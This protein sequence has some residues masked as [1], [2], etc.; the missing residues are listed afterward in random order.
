MSDTSVDFPFA[1]IPDFISHGLDESRKQIAK[2][3][4]IDATYLRRDG[5]LAAEPGGTGGKFNLLSL[6]AWLA[7]AERAGVPFVPARRIGCVPID[8]VCRHLWDGEPIEGED[9]AAWTA[10]CRAAGEMGP[11]EILRWDFASSGG[12]K[13]RMAT[14]R[15]KPITPEETRGLLRRENGTVEPDVDM[16]I[17]DLYLQYVTPMVPVHARPWVDAT[18]IPGRDV[19]DGS[20]GLYPV[21]WRVLVHNGEIIGISNYYVQAEMDDDAP[22]RYALADT[23][24][25]ALKMIGKAAEL[26][27]LPANAH[28]LPEPDGFCATLDFLIR[29]SDGKPVLIE[30]GPPLG[31]G[32][33]PCC[34]MNS[35]K[36]DGVALRLEPASR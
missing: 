23:A 11:D 18:M 36:I 28:L 9:L 26:N 20:K 35:E 19:N 2:E 29:K 4:E 32:A 8:A 22:G 5:I 34:F 33:H 12:V 10:L 27:L 16:R 1:S 25:L 3:Q 24:A 13:Y 6:E 21:E 30:G 17:V 7:L 31:A 15:E 14:G